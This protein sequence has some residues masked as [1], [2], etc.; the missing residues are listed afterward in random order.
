MQLNDENYIYIK[1][2]FDVVISACY[3]TVLYDC[4]KLFSFENLERSS[5]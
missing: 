3:E 4:Q 2:R 5:Y 1:T